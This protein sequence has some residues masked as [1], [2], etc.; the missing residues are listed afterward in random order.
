MKSKKILITALLLAGMTLPLVSCGESTVITLWVGEES[1][2][3]YQQVCNEYVESHP[4][5]KYTISVTGV[6]TGTVGGAMATD[7][8]ACGDIIVTAHDNIGKLVERGLVYPFTDETL[9][10]QVTDDNPASFLEI[11]RAHV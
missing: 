3:F 2:E 5:F 1:A 10:N 6:D 9:I 7:N 4:D 11:G 8:T